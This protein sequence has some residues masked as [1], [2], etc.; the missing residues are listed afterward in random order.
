MDFGNDVKL[1]K[2]EVLGAATFKEGQVGMR[3][4]PASESVL[5]VDGLVVVLQKVME[6]LLKFCHAKG[7]FF[8]SKLLVRCGVQ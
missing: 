3:Q 7:G 8:R 2:V 5:G 1:G 4:S 6:F